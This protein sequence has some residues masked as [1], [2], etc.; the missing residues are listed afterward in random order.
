MQN[1]RKN[2]SDASNVYRVNT[3]RKNSTRQKHEPTTA[4]KQN[5]PPQ[6]K[7][8]T[9]PTPLER[10]NGSVLKQSINQQQMSGK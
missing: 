8:E 6:K 4:K 3:Q 9:T 7:R 10:N 1:A 2:D 5:T